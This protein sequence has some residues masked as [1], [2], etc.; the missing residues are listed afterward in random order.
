MQLLPISRQAKDAIFHFVHTPG[1]DSILRSCLIPA[2]C[3][4]KAFP[5]GCTWPIIG[6]INGVTP[7][8]MEKAYKIALA[9]LRA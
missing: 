6:H 4:A 5:T 1:P 7:A 8:E 3:L 9:K 2:R